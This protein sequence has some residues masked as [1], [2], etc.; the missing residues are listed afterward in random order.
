MEYDFCP[1][2]GKMKIGFRK[3]GHWGDSVIEWFICI[4]CD[5][6]VI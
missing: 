1:F 5:R 4:D 3:K 2:C 6:E